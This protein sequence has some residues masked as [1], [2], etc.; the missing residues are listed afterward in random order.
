MWWD[1]GKLGV[2][3]EVESSGATQ[4]SRQTVSSCF[5]Q[6]KVFMPDVDQ[7]AGFLIE[8][9]LLFTVFLWLIHTLA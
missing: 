8:N 4:R 7:H 2:F 1:V 9:I 6:D 3:L 5:G